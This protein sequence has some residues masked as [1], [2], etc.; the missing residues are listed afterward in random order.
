VFAPYSSEI[1]ALH[2]RKQ[3]QG[4]GIGRR[5]IGAASSYLCDLGKMSVFITVLQRN[6]RARRLY[7]N[8]GGE[9]LG[10]VKR[11]DVDGWEIV[12]VAYAWPNVFHLIHQPPV[13]LY[14][15][16]IQPMLP[17][18]VAAAQRVILGTA[19]G[20]FGWEETLDETM[21]KSMRDGC[22]M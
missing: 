22:K 16:T 4:Q 21:K 11:F 1:A 14:N 20:I 2:V 5:L 6:E 8:L 12:E 7:A 17:E 3:D 9:Y 18:Q 15:I 10:E 13:N 19:H